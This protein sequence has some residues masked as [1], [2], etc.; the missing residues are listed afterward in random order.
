MCWHFLAAGLH[1]GH[2]NFCCNNVK[3]DGETKI[4]KAIMCIHIY[5]G[6][7]FDME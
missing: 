3:S 6:V 5:G 2:L 7:W 4:V 1:Q